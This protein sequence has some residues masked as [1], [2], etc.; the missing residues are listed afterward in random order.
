MS[1][2]KGA[3]KKRVNISITEDTLER[4][5]QYA[6]ENH[7]GDGVSGAITDLAWKAK[8]KNSQIRGQA[9]LEVK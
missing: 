2:T 8:V 1:R 3:E 6:W 9:S 4:L 7:L 5:K